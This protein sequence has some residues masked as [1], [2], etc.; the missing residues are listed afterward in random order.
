MQP[1]DKSD[2]KWLRD[3]GYSGMPQ[4]MASYGFKMPDDFDDAKK[5]LAQFRDEQQK[6]WE[7]KQPAPA[8]STPRTSQAQIDE[9]ILWHKRMGHPNYHELKRTAAV[10]TGVPEF[11]KTIN[12]DDIPVCA[13]CTACGMQDR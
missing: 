2:S 3:A 12:V 1:K 10:T 13:T 6:E 7:A 5:L 4:F 11:M 9:A 8:A